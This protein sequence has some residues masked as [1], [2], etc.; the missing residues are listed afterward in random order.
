[1][2]VFGVRHGRE[3][4]LTGSTPF[5]T[6]AENVDS[7]SRL[8]LKGAVVFALQSA[9]LGFPVDGNTFQFLSV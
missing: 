2:K 3:A 1:M 7:A 8:F 9:P 5:D 4:F 6:D